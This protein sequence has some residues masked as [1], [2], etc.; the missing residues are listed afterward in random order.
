MLELWGVGSQCRLCTS[1][2]NELYQIYYT[3]WDLKKCCW[4][5]LLERLFSLFDNRNPIFWFINKVRF[6]VFMP[7]CSNWCPYVCSASLLCLMHKRKLSGSNE[8]GNWVDDVGVHRCQDNNH[9]EI[10]RSA[11]DHDPWKGSFS[12]HNWDPIFWSWSNFIFL[13]LWR[14]VAIPK[15][16]F[17]QLHYYAWC[18]EVS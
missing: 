2:K 1:N 16:L 15:L 11:A 8:K 12:S 7:F 4:S 13:T 18:T 5:W 3:W 17:V 14:S 10:M 6:P 9:S